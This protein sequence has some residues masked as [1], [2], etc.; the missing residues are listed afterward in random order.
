MKLCTTSAGY[1]LRR[2]NY[3]GIGISREK[4]YSHYLLTA[5]GLNDGCAKRLATC[6][7]VPRGDNDCRECTNTF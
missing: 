7:F 6:F 2:R 1:A 5:L 3:S 4:G